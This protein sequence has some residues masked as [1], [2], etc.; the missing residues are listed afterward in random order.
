[1]PKNN[2]AVLLGSVGGGIL[3]GGAG[4]GAIGCKPE[5]NSFYCKSSRFVMILKNILFFVLLL[6][7]IYYVFK[8]RSSFMGKRR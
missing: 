6:A 2:S 5:D 3:S 7:F 4:I 8:N 1:M